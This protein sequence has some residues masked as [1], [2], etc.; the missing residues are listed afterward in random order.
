ML[1]DGILNRNEGNESCS[2]KQIKKRKRK[3]LV[4]ACVIDVLMKQRRV[5]ELGMNVIAFGWLKFVPRRHKRVVQLGV[6]RVALV[7]LV[8]P[9]FLD[10]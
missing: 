1:E 3:K 7:W 10:K 9:R 5:V 8:F 2:Q 6:S 4:F